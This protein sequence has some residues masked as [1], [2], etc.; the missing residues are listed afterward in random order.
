MVEAKILFESGQF[1]WSLN[2]S[3]TSILVSTRAYMS[4]QDYRPTS[5]GGH[6]VVVTFIKKDDILSKFAPTVDRMRRSRH[7]VTY[8]EYNIITQRG[9]ES[10]LKTAKEF[11]SDVE[12]ALNQ[13]AFDSS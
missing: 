5:K 11:Y 2:A 7:R 1:D 8:D 6:V 4:N 9:A 3:Y 10:A 12:A 13:M